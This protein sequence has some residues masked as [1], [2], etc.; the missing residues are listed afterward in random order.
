MAPRT[1]APYSTDSLQVCAPDAGEGETV[2][3]SASAD[4]RWVGLCDAVRLR[5][6]KRTMVG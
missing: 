1:G 2:R 4:E 5:G 6:R 3:E